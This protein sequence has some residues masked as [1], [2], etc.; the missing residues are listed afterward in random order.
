[1]SEWICIKEFIKKGTK[2][3]YH[4]EWAGNETYIKLPKLIN[5]KHAPWG[6]LYCDEYEDIVNSEN[7]CKILLIDILDKYYKEYKG[8]LSKW[9][10]DD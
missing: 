3:I 1:M 9:D 4:E 5:G 10:K 7:P 2:R 6:E 8:K